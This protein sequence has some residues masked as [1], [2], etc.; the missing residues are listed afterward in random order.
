MKADIRTL[1]NDICERVLGK[2]SRVA[3]S[4]KELQKQAAA[5]GGAHRAFAAGATNTWQQRTL[6]LE[7]QL[8]EYSISAEGGDFGSQRLVEVRLAVLA[9]LARSQPCG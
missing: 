5:G 1:H 7:E 3:L 4:I 2:P 8:A 6:T 9:V